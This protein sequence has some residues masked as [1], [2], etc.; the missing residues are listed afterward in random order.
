LT[1]TVF[2][3]VNDTLGHPIG[4]LLLKAVGERLRHTVRDSDRVAR[5]GGDEFAILARD[6]TDPTDAGIL[7]EKLLTS[8]AT[9]FALKGHEVHASAS[10]GATLSDS[11]NGD[12]EALLAHA[13][14]A[15]Y[16]AKAEGRRTFRFFTNSMD[17]DV[18]QRVALLADLREAIRQK[19]LF[20][21][22]QPQVDL[23]TGALVGLE[24][25]V[26]WRHPARG[27]VPPGEFIPA[28]ENSGLIISLGHYVLGEACQ[29]IRRWLDAGAQVPRVAVNVSPTQ[30]KGSLELGKE[31]GEIL[32]QTAVDPSLLEIELTES[33]LM[34]ASRR[35]NDALEDLRNRGI[36]IAIDD[37]GT[38]YSCLDYLRQHPASKIKIAQTF[39][40]EITRN[41]G[42]AAITR[43]TISLG[44]ELGLTVIAEGVE[45]LDQVRLLR[46]WGCE[47]AQGFLFAKPLDVEAMTAALRDGRVRSELI[48]VAEERSRAAAQ[49]S[50]S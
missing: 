7:A 25:L 50:S 8:L 4:D 14:V 39:V 42:S 16:R 37:F 29:Q 22:Y 24:A 30:F 11:D 45:N 2:K 3:D 10:I 33:T 44:R 48:P 1:S 6:L 40:G 38:G 43:A 18:R 34:E 41:A 49:G 17:V 12:A 32:E 20:L 36:R 26:R 19:Q 35:N 28:A 46:E 9:P 31:I 23:A 47:E 15:L 13:D 27:I 21:M 5:F